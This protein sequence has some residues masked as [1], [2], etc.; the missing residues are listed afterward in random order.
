M[1]NGEYSEMIELPVSTCEMV[2]APKRKRK[3]FKGRLIKTVNKKTEEQES[4]PSATVIEQPAAA[5]E[6]VDAPAASLVIDYDKKTKKLKKAKGKQTMAD[7]AEKKGFKFDLV[8]AEVIAVF[9][10]IVAI[11]LTN[12]FWEDSGIN[13]M[14]RSVFGAKV[15]K[16]VDSRT[17]KDL[18]V[19][20]PSSYAD[21]TV[22]GGVMTF[23]EAAAVYAPANG[24]V[25]EINET[26]GVFTLTVSHSDVFKTVI[27]GADAVYVKVGDA[28][29]SNI[30]VAYA[31]EGTKVAMYDE[32]TLAA[33]YTL[34][35]GKIVWQS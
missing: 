33:D 20:A 32:G 31:S 21:V 35:G 30:P 26:D 5:Q 4:K 2:I 34:D 7:V 19:S 24:T 14:I 10:L 18:A 17:A 3:L 15:E 29:Y 25:T 27:S 22:D 9:V 8:A 16:S 1:S 12:I 11:L 28:V 23:N 13:V 6:N